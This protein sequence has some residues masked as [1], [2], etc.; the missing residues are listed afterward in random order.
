MSYN[1]IFPTVPLSKPDNEV[2]EKGDRGEVRNVLVQIAGNRATWEHL[3]IHGAVWRVNQER[4]DTIFSYSNGYN[5]KGDLTIPKEDRLSRA[6][7]KRVTI[8]ESSTNIEECVG[9]LV[10]GLPPNEF[11]ANG[12]GVACFLTGQGKTVVCK[13]FTMLFPDFVCRQ[14]HDPAGGV[15][16][17][18]QH[19]A[20]YGLDEPVP[21]VHE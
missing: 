20:R 16:P 5:A 17:L 11:T 13:H 2:L 10:D 14:E 19:G 18:G 12:D 6:M 9:V 15:L 4:A 3:G 7:I 21:A 1:K 8:L